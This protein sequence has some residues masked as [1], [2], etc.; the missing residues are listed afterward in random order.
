VLS[1]LFCF[2]GLLA[3]GVCFLQ[4]EA[5]HKLISVT[6]ADIMAHNV[7]CFNEVKNTHCC[8]DK[9]SDLFLCEISLLGNKR[10]G[11]VNGIMGFFVGKHGSLLPHYEGKWA[12]A[13]ICRQ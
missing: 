11:V 9:T 13:A 2:L 5:P 7:I 1:Y 10:K 8:I 6:A 3:G 12:H 4:S